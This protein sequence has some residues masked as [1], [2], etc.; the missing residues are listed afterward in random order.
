MSDTRSQIGDALS[1]KLTPEQLETLVDDVLASTKNAW[2]DINCKHCG[3]GGRYQV[4]IKDASAATRGLEILSNQ[5]WG[6]PQDDKV[7]A[8]GIVFKRTVVYDGVEVEP[9][10]VVSPPS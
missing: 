9:A 7:E 5:A 1:G 2:A 6:R 10:G 8:E 4:E 3:R